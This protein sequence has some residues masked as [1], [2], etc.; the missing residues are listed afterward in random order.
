MLLKRCACI[1]VTVA[2]FFIPNFLAYYY[3][4]FNFSLLSHKNK[5]DWILAKQFYSHLESCAFGLLCVF[6]G[7]STA[8]PGTTCDE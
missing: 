6:Y 1:F 4:I 5:R 8:F 7:N 3:S 2:L